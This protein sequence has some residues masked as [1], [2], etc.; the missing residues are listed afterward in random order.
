MSEVSDR[1]ALNALEELALL[2]ERAGAHADADKLRR[3]GLIETRSTRT[4]G[5]S[6]TWIAAPLDFGSYGGPIAK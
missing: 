1:G 2:W 4:S 3:F 5:T 6:N